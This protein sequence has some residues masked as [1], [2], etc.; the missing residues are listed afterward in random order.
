MTPEQLSEIRAR[1]LTPEEEAE[2]R[3]AWV[4]VGSWEET[5]RSEYYE[6]PLCNGESEVAGVTFD[7]SNVTPATLQGFGIGKGLAAAELLAKSTGP[8]LATLDATRAEL[9]EAREALRGLL[10][11][12]AD[13]DGSNRRRARAV[14]ERKPR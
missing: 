1:A 6:C 7:A 3:A 9:E 14:L 10:E 4:S 2:V 11:N 12:P 5:E 13:I 8:L